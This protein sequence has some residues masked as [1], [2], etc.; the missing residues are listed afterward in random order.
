MRGKKDEGIF[1]QNNLPIHNVS[2][3]F[4]HMNEISI[5]ERDM[6]GNTILDDFIQYFPNTL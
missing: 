1:L 2:E 5:N 6:M 3:N 4:K